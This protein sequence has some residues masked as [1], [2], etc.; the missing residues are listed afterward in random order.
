MTS[1]RDDLNIDMDEIDRRIDQMPALNLRDPKSR[2]KTSV[3]IDEIVK[4]LNLE[5]RMAEATK[6][7]DNEGK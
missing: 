1:A 5:A 7:H 3:N 4:S 6:A 2:K